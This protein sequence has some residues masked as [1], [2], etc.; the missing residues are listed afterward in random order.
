MTDGSV[1]VLLARWTA[2]RGRFTA[3]ERT[4]LNQAIIGQVIC[5]RGVVLDTKAL[6]TE[7]TEKLREA[8]A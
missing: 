4:R 5:P 6:P 2:V 7:L 3:E 8:I 1:L